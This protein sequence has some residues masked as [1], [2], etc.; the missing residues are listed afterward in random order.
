M[1]ALIGGAEERAA[2]QL[3]KSTW[4]RKRGNESKI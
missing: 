2:N 3:G 1:M 4:L